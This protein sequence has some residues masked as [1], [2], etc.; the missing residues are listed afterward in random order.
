MAAL[1]AKVLSSL[2]T[3][4]SAGGVTRTRTLAEFESTETIVKSGPVR[5]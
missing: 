1:Y 5:L 4:I 2:R 3:P